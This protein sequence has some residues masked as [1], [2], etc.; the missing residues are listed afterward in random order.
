M[1]TQQPPLHKIFDLSDDQTRQSLYPFQFE[2]ESEPEK[3][4]P[5]KTMKSDDEDEP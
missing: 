4:P 1:A 2:D 5:K 3:E